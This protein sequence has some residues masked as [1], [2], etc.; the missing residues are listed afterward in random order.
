MLFVKNTQ[1]YKAKEK[2]LRSFF[3]IEEKEHLIFM[4][5]FESDFL[6]LS[7]KNATFK[8]NMKKLSEIHQN[9]E[10]EIMLMSENSINSKEKIDLKYESVEIN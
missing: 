1:N 7:Q 10:S 4:D 9:L 2:I 6:Y 3:E 5:V 8:K